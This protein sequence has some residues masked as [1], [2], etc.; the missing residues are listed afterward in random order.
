MIQEIK[1]SA[2][3]ETKM[4]AQEEIKEVTKKRVYKKKVIEVSGQSIQSNDVPEVDPVVVES[5]ELPK[6]KYQRRQSKDG[7]ATP[8]DTR[9]PKETPIIDKAPEPEPTIPFPD[10]THREMS[11]LANIPSPTT[12]SD[13]SSPDGSSH[14]V[15][16]SAD[17]Q[18]DRGNDSI[19]LYAKYSPEGRRQTA[20][21]DICRLYPFK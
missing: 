5:I 7:I 2:Q 19:S 15:V 11:H 1:M 9:K 13:S 8:L 16:A 12:E 18:R 4:S 17:S 3:E 20:K 21:F 10:P 14:R 6:R